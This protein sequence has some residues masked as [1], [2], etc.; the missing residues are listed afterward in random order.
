MS[1]ARVGHSVHPFM[2]G[3]FFQQV[4]GV[5]FDRLD[6]DVQA[7]VSSLRALAFFVIRLCSRDGALL[8]PCEAAEV[9]WIG[10]LMFYPRLLFLR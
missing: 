6:L 4:M 8:R 1:L 3:E 9:F 7:P 5:V 2:D 10:A